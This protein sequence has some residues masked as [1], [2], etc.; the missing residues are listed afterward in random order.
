[1]VSSNNVNTQLYSGKFIFYE[2]VT[3]VRETNLE[4]QETTPTERRETELISVDETII[5]TEKRARVNLGE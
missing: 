1:M 4:V 5:K 3:F 2:D